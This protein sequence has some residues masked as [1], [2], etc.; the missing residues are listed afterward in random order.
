MIRDILEALITMIIMV[1]GPVSIIMVEGLAWSSIMAPSWPRATIYYM[2][3]GAPDVQ[4]TY[5]EHEVMINGWAWIPC[6]GGESRG[7]IA[8]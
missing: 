7:C 2:F 8:A 3:H 5:I 1:E 4:R 6:R